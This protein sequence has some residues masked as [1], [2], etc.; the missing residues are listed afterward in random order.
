M[1]NSPRLAV[2]L[3]TFN[4]VNYLGQQLDSI[5]GQTF[6]NLMIVT[7]DDGS[8]DG[9]AELV[10]QYQARDPQRFHVVADQ[11]GNLGPAGSFSLLMQYALDHRA[12]L[13]LDTV[14]VLLCDQDDV[15]QPDKVQRQLAALLA[16]E[17]QWPDQP[18][19]VHSDLVVVDATLQPI[20]D[21]FLAYHGL[22]GRRNALRNI[23]FSNT[24]TGCTA[25][26][27][28]ALLRKALPIPATAIM[29]DWWLALVAAAFGQLHFLP[30]P[31][32]LYRQ[33]GGNTLGARE[34][35]PRRL[36]SRTTW[37]RL[38]QK[39]PDPMLFD[40]A[41]QAESFADRYGAELQWQERFNLQLAGRLRTDSLLL[42]RL[43]FR[44][45]RY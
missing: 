37:R 22:D 4:G 9:T 38:L 28:E 16:L 24:V 25:L 7:R 45:L 6:S 13:G 1:E 39:N 34:W 41:R 27:N 2:L 15:W 40:V 36:L 30:E 14:R 10:Q 19:L 29:H 26:L 5:L 35:Q 32:V 42:Q 17:T 21:S 8:T 44:V 18:L 31:A 43:L 12:S 3:P 23:V 20:A 33:H 11:W